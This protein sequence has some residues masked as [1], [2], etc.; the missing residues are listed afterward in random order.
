VPSAVEPIIRTTR[1]Y[2]CTGCG[3]AA[4]WILFVY[5]VWEGCCVDTVCIQGVGRLLC[6]YC[7]CTG[8]WKAVWILSVY[9]VC[10]N[11]S[12]GFNNELLTSKQ[13]KKVL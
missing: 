1:L 6:G 3:K 2:V 4:V 7:L 10:L 11:A 13:S 5:R 12:A 8:C 9:R